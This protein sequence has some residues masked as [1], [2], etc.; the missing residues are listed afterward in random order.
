MADRFVDLKL[1][2]KSKLLFPFSTGDWDL[3]TVIAGFKMR[4][5]HSKYKEQWTPKAFSFYDN[6]NNSNKYPENTSLFQ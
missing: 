5:N 4:L 6:N 1:I 3:Q 2:F